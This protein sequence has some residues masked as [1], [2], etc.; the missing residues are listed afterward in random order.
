[1]GSKS[2]VA[3]SLAG[4]FGSR[5]NRAAEVA[6]R[7]LIRV[8]RCESESSE[9]RNPSNGY[10]EVWDRAHAASVNSLTAFVKKIKALLTNESGHTFFVWIHNKWKE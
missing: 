9:S 10:K 4:R 8:V 3:L 7:S 6:T 5:V 2:E 1:M